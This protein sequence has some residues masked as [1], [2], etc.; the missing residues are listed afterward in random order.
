LHAS[1][2]RFLDSRASKILNRSA[3]P[4]FAD[5]ANADV[6][7]MSDGDGVLRIPGRARRRRHHRGGRRRR[8]RLHECHRVRL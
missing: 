5:G 1:F 6:L 7:Q 8:V 4:G 2:V 3:L